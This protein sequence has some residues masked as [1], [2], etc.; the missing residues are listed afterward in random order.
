M[1]N[2][3]YLC[4]IFRNRI[5]TMINRSLLRI[6]SVQMLYSFYVS[7]VGDAE[8]IEEELRLSI[9]KS[10]DLYYCVLQLIV[11]AHRTTSKAWKH[12]VTVEKPEEDPLYPLA[13]CSRFRENRFAAQ[14]DLNEELHDYMSSRDMEWVWEIHRNVV[15][16]VLERIAHSEYFRQY[17]AETSSSYDADKRLWRDVLQNELMGNEEFENAIEDMNI[18]WNDDLYNAISFGVKTI[19]H[20]GLKA[21]SEQPLMPIMRNAGE[22]EY[23]KRLVRYAMVNYEEIDKKIEPL[24]TGWTLD[25]LP[26]MDLTVMRTAIAE[27]L[28]FDD[29]YVGVTI[30][31]YIEIAKAYCGD[32]SIDYISAV[33]YG[34]GAEI[35]P[36]SVKPKK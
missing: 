11:E 31:E 35:D 1:K 3:L 12:L 36:L 16:N 2:N 24:L 10:S 33:I 32:N 25:R 20:F 28:A 21:G 15:F 6:K 17:A 13:S 4:T 23:S 30:N 26:V 19:K 7:K 8:R 5:F 27:M 14:L 18:Y 9:S 22:L 34:V 29:I